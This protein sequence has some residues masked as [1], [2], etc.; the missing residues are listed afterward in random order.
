M[1]QLVFCEE[2]GKK[3]KVDDSSLVPGKKARYKC[4]SCSHVIEVMKESVPEPVDTFPIEIPTPAAAPRE[5]SMNHGVSPLASNE[6][7][8]TSKRGLSIV[9]M[10]LVNFLVYAVL[11]AAVLTLV[12]MTY[13]PTLL[14]E[15]VNLRT[16]AISKSLSTAV[17]QPVLLRNYLLINKTAEAISQL[18][19]VAY[20]AVLN[21][22]GVVVA[23]L[24]GDVERFSPE[25][26]AKVKE[27]GFPKEVAAQNPISTGSNES[28]KDFVLGGMKIHDVA[29]TIEGG[30]GVVHVGLFSEDVEAAVKRSPKPLL[31]ILAALFILGSLFFILLA[32]FIS[33]PIKILTDAAQRISLGELDLPI[34][35]SQ[36]GEIG[37]LATSLDRMRF[38]I[39]SAMDRLRRR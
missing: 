13:V 7:V 37:E 4:S 9:S 19:G 14:Q 35:I 10:L 33:R 27:V 3:Y 23:G 32:R 5:Q 38:S 21:K 15:Q 29:Q 12:Y 2:C 22:K 24:F 26:T 31:I 11:Q 25:F 17:S 1:V 6:E 8:K 20:V 16:S 36:G 28:A 18:P 39:Q 30:T 34:N